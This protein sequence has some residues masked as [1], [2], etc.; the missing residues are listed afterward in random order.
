MIVV[1]Y[2][3][4]PCHNGFENLDKRVTA[5]RKRAAEVRYRFLTCLDLAEK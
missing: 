3:G 5:L 2:V 4:I 1:F